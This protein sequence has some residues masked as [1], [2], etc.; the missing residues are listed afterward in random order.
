MKTLHLAIISMIVV[1]TL[2]ISIFLLNPYHYP[3]EYN[4]VKI[5]P[6]NVIPSNPHVNDAIE[7]NATFQNSGY[8][9]IMMLASIGS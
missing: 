6:V 3:K 7:F 9:E 5:T 1:A 2:G 8:W 4:P